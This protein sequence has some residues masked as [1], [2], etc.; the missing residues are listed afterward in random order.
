MGQNVV[1]L[2]PG[3]ESE[4]EN[5]KGKEYPQNYL[6]N[7]HNHIQ[8]YKRFKCDGVCCGYARRQTAGERFCLEGT[9]Y[10]LSFR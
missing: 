7:I 5:T 2:P 6:T 8:G 10:T 3:L 1:K 9:G 4:K